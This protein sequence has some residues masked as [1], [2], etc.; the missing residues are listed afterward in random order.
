MKFKQI[1]QALMQNMDLYKVIMPCRW[2]QPYNI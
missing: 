2:Q 1:N